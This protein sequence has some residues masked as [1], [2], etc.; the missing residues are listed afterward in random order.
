MDAYPLCKASSW[1][2][3]SGGPVRLWEKCGFKKVG[4]VGYTKGEPIPCEEE[5]V[6]IMRKKW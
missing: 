1:N 2:Q 3:V 6:L 4:K 5:E